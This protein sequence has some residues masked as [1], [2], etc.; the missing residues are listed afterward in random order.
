MYRLSEKERLNAPIH[1]LLNNG[2][3]FALISEVG[4]VIKPAFYEY[5]LAALKK[6]IRKSKVVE[7]KS[8]LTN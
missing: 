4:A 6:N 1:S 3:R 8:L 2:Y 7:I 5:Q